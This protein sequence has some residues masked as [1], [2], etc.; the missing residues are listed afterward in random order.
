MYYRRNLLIKDGFPDDPSKVWAEFHRVRKHLMN[1][2]QNNI[3]KF[4][5]ERIAPADDPDHNGV[6]DIR[7][8]GTGSSASLVDNFPYIYSND[9]V[10][11]T[12][13]DDNALWR[14]F[15]EHF[16]LD[17]FSRWESTW[18]VGSCCE[19]EGGGTSWANIGM[20]VQWGIQSSAGE[21]SVSHGGCTMQPAGVGGT[22]FNSIS[23]VTAIRVPAGSFRVYPVAKVRWYDSSASI[24][25]N[26]TGVPTAEYP[27]M[28][29]NKANL[30]AF[31]IYR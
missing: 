25:D 10:T 1:L 18:I 7:A 9:A 31:G 2:D 29:I 12:H 17:L 5:K 11:R 24:S 14:K 4:A 3:K 27:E 16:Y 22:H 15:R 28:T 23:C 13:A 20:N 19:V 6:S 30:F 21:R 8:E 26:F